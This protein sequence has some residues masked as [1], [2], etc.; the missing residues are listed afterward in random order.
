MGAEELLDLARSGE[1]D[2]MQALAVLRNPRCPTEAA[3]LL[4]AQRML[5]R[6]DSI[7]ALL[8]GFRGMPLAQSLNLMATLP[9]LALLDIAQAPRTPPQVRRH[10]EQRL[11][12]RIESMTRGERVALARRCHRPMVRQV[13]R[14]GDA[15][16]LEAFLDNP[17]ATE[18]D[19]LVILNTAEPTPEFIAIVVRHHKWGQY[20]GVRAAVVRNP[21]TPLSLALSVLVQLSR[22]DLRDLCDRRDVPDAVMDAAQALKEKQDR[23]IRH[24]GS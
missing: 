21:R 9:W 2:E 16:I 17:R 14:T 8:A 11:L 4:A 10:A 24:V 1:V 3:E 5:L 20:R 19:I 13:T 6:R 15:M 7:R 12:G 23:G 18:N 22:R